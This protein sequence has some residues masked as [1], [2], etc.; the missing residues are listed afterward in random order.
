MSDTIDSTLQPELQAYANAL[1]QLRPSE[2][3]DARI[4]AALDAW[5]PAAAVRASWRNPLAWIAVAASLAI[6]GAGIA[7]LRLRSGMELRAVGTAS[8]VRPRLHANADGAVAPLPVGPVSLWPAEAAIFRVRAGLD[9][10]G[11]VI[12]PDHARPGERQYWVDVRVANDGTMR[13]VHV[14]PANPHSV[15]LSP[16]ESGPAPP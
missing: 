3:L 10:A 15:P 9:P 1:R 7:L 2:R 12:P 13:I 6:V 5:A 16:A 4:E 14:F 8:A 11:M